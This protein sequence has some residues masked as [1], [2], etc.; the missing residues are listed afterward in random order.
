[1][2]EARAR[3]A[4][5]RESVDQAEENLRVSRELYGAGL[6]NNTQVLDAVTLDINARNNRDSALLDEQLAQVR[7]SYAVG[8]L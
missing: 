2:R 7:L 5:A 3:A 8:A 4:A 6:A 1:M